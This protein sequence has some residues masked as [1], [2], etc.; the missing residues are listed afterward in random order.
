MSELMQIVSQHAARECSGISPSVWAEIERAITTAFPGERV[1][2]PHQVTSRKDAIAE[3][4][5]KLPSAV[6]AKRFGVTP[7]WVNR[8]VREGRK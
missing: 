3:A 8:I 2:I 1:Y 4:T 7:R 6:V 5:R